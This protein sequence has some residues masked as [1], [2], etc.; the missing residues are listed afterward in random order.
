MAG[1]ALLLLVCR[2]P[3]V[4]EVPDRLP[5][6]LLPVVR[7]T[8]VRARHEGGQ[9]LALAVPPELVEA[10]ATRVADLLADQLGGGAEPDPWLDVPAA[11]RYLACGDE[12]R[13]YDLVHQGRL[14]R[15][16]DGRRLLFR[17]EWLDAALKTPE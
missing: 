6:R 9:S 14:Q 1:L 13:I 17:R 16:K 7:A 4:L 11:A 5:A 12:Q 2:G 8:T 15:A 3:R 10:V